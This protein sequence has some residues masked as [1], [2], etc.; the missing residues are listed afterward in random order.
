MTNDELNCQTIVVDKLP[1]L[2]KTE[3]QLVLLRSAFIL[4]LIKLIPMISYRLIFLEEI[5]FDLPL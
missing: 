2:L 4:C 5:I 1:S 3:T